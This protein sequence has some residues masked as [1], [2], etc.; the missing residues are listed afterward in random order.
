[1]KLGIL[2]PFPYKSPDGYG[3]FGGVTTLFRHHLSRMFK[4]QGL[5][6]RKLYK[7]ESLEGCSALLI[8]VINKH[9]ASEECRAVVEKAKSMGMPVSAILH[10]DQHEYNNSKTKNCRKLHRMID[11]FAYIGR[12]D[13][14]PRSVLKWPSWI[15][16]THPFYPDEI[17]VW[18]GVGK[19][20]G[21][22]SWTRIAT[23]KCSHMIPKMLPTG[24][25]VHFFSKPDGAAYWYMKDRSKRGIRFEKA[26]K[27]YEDYGRLLPFKF[28]FDLSV[29]AQFEMG[30]SQY[31]GMEMMALGHVPISFS[32][33]NYGYNAIWLPDPTWQ[34][35]RK[36]PKFFVDE[37]T[38]GEIV[39]DQVSPRYRKQH[40]RMVI[41][42]RRFLERFHD[43]AR[44]KYNWFKLIGLKIGG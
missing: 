28:A 2:K 17:G 27:G 1:V 26:L 10:G 41:E 39:K 24:S 30:R 4:E 8:P 44:V 33:W 13:V 35:V 21:F 16:V 3:L 7:P 38:C 15:N 11:N 31:V 43:P 9:T 32:S 14:Y 29:P 20:Q 42:N 37:K 19:R 6:L 36:R 12:D 18:N 5:S 25:K 22:C 34:I 40:E 23:F